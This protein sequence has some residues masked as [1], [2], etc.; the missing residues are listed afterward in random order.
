MVVVRVAICQLGV[1]GQLASET[2]GDF[3]TLLLDLMRDVPNRDAVWLRQAMKVS[4][5]R[6]CIWCLVELCVCACRGSAQT[7]NA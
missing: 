1:C 3:K 5:A 7:T 2:S 4:L 6:H